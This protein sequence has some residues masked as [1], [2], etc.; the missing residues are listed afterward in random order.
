MNKK[1]KIFLTFF[2]KGFYKEAISLNLTD[3]EKEQFFRD[4][5][6]LTPKERTTLITKIKN[7]LISDIY[8][9]FSQVH[10][11]MNLFV[12]FHVNGLPFLISFL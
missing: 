9:F 10:N 2:E 1:T 11:I 7:Q 6:R 12:L 3:L 4:M 8:N 5:L